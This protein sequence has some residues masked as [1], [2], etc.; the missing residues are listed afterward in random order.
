MYIHFKSSFLNKKAIILYIFKD[1]SFLIEKKLRVYFPK[2]W[3]KKKLI[4]FFKNPLVFTP[5]KFSKIITYDKY[6]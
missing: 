5:N 1:Q 2:K 3:E 6:I 4:N